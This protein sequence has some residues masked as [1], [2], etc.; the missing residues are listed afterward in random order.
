MQADPTS[1]QRPA[2]TIGRARRASNDAATDQPT[3]DRRGH[4]V[5]LLGSI[6]VL[7]AGLLVDVNAEGAIFLRGLPRVSFP[8]ICPLRRFFGISCPTCGVTR[9]MV[10]MLQG[11]PSE[12]FAVHRLGWLV[13]AAIVFQIPYQTWC[14]KSRR[15]M[16]VSTRFA[17]FALAVFML[18]L[19]LNWLIP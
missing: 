4:W 2:E 9:S 1:N 3:R 8:V 11:R 7:I 10:F 6:A 17:Q 13:L 12:S 16:S 14:L 18:L 19:V 5:V 15:N